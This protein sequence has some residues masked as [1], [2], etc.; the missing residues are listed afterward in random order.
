MR[1]FAWNKRF[2]HQVLL[3]VAQRG[4]RKCNT[5][6]NFCSRH[7]HGGRKSQTV[8]S[9]IATQPA[10]GRESSEAFVSECAITGT[11]S[12][13]T[14]Q[15]FAPSLHTGPGVTQLPLSKGGMLRP[16]RHFYPLSVL[17]RG[18]SNAGKWT[19]GL[20]YT[21][22]LIPL[23]ISTLSFPL[24]ETLTHVIS[25]QTCWESTESPH[26]KCWWPNGNFYASPKSLAAS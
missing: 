14:L 18:F 22:N 10:G 5:R 23:M 20:V 7:R 13:N 24:G 16:C 8:G 2:V 4:D 21:L 25:V 3:G 19:S 12:M 6:T 1:T 26:Y 11:A 9:N 15:E 17:I